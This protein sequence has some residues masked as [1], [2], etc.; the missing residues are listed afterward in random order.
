MYCKIYSSI[1]KFN[2][3]FIDISF[4][5]KYVYYDVWKINQFKFTI[6]FYVIIRYKLK[7]VISYK[8]FDSDSF[9]SV[10]DIYCC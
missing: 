9:V 5:Y 3:I 2:L 1:K 10:M 8:Y 4:V 7:I 6:K